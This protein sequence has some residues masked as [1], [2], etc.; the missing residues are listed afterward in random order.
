MKL[1]LGI[2]I[3]G[4]F[5][6]IV[7]VDQDGRVQATKTSS[8]PPRFE[9]GFLN[10]IAKLADLYGVSSE[11]LLGDAEIVLHGT[12]V[13][14]NAAVQMRGS[15]LGVLTTKGH[16]DTLPL[17][18]ASG[19]TK[20]IPLEQ[21]LRASHTNR[22]EP[23]VP[24]TRILEVGERI[25]VAGE[26]VVPLD[27]EGVAARVR[28]LVEME[29]EALAVCFLWSI[30][31]GAHERRAAEI[32][33][34]VAPELFIVASHEVSARAG[35]Y[36]R[37]VAT[38]VNAFVGPETS[39]YME[40]LEQGLR[41]GGLDS[42]LLI[43]QANGG[44]TT[45]AETVERPATTI[46]SG[47]AAGVAASAV[48]ARRHQQP[49]VITTDMGGTSF[50]VGLIVGGEVVRASSTVLNQYE[51]YVTRTDVESI[52]SGGG[53]I[54]S[55]AEGHSALRV[56]PESA[57]AFPGPACYGRGGE[58]AT[59]TDANLVLGY[60]DPE[61][62]LGGEITLDSGA[63]ERA[64][65]EVGE[66]L[67]MSAIE[68]AA[69][70]KRIV[71][72]Q[73]ADLIRQMT[74]ERGLDPRDFA[75]HAF[76]G[77][78]G[79]H[80]AG[81]IH[82][83]GGLQAVVPLGARAATWSAFG[84]ASADIVHIAEHAEVMPSPYDPAALDLVFEKLEAE[85]GEKLDSEN[86]PAERRRIER[87]VEMKYSLQIHQVEVPIVAG[88][89]DQ[90]VV[91]ALPG[92][93]LA[94]YEEHFGVG[95]A[96]EGAGTQIVLCRVVGRGLLPQPSV[97]ADDST[98]AAGGLTASGSRKVAWLEGHGAGFELIESPVYR[99]EDL[100]PGALIEGPAVVEGTTT[101][102]GIPP[103]Y[104]GVADAAGNLVLELSESDPSAAAPG[105]LQAG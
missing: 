6:D 47:P 34:E 48:L 14:T 94:R 37:F 29:V 92:R 88:K 39:G 11:Q 43:M 103:L 40:R 54:I 68:V 16:A 9:E 73:M 70:A 20:G 57:G 33:R 25:D 17:M 105:A 83:L 56:G 50:D 98:E 42:P 95:A 28:E 52:G 4:T 87:T 62:F 22:P 24:R 41:A 81:Y 21:M 12:T 32:A 85:V 86:I 67:G 63:A 97:F 101:T 55:Y 8:T 10:G 79:M 19:R 71:D 74:V 26:V 78:A 69:S 58:R 1:Y 23:L 76:G 5:T 60:L 100:P 15:K 38:A 64:L 18:R 99:S 93:F 65:G 46:G 49:N 91:E 35:E 89:V 51:F 75:V 45:A 30:T 96:L 84:C 59:V 61:Y 90:E 31:N 13:A 3:G 102:I 7:G 77:A 53:S 44:V 2:D 27:E 66:P 104:A 82:E 72:A 36:E 80:V